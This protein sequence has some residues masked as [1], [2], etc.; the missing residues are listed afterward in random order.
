MR[1]VEEKTIELEK[2]NKKLAAQ[3][4]TSHVHNSNAQSSQQEQS[5]TV[6]PSK[7]IENEI[8]LLK[9]KLKKSEQ[10]IKVLK[11]KLT[12][13]GIET[14]DIND[15]MDEINKEEQE[16]QQ[17]QLE[18]QEGNNNNE[19]QVD[20]E[21]TKTQQ[22]IAEEL[23]EIEVL[24][25]KNEQDMLAL[26]KDYEIQLSVINAKVSESFLNFFGTF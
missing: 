20:S 11:R 3:A 7:E 10:E 17:Q 26:R 19:N 13:A 9:L 25:Y 12:K 5:G 24:K 15:E 18:N 22:I 16:N 23:K 6:A 14:H 1:Q 2:R 8:Q 21:Q 4:N